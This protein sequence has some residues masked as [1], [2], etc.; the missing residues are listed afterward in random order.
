MKYKLNATEI[1][2]IRYM[3]ECVACGSAMDLNENAK[4]IAER[5]SQLTSNLTMSKDNQ[6]DVL[7]YYDD[8]LPSLNYT[9]KKN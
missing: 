9:I 8:C 1:S 7:D 4:K 6:V 2:L 3:S 5:I